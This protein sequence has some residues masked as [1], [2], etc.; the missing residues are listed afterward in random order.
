MLYLKPPYYL[1]NGVTVFRD[2]E[3]P[4]QFYF[5]PA[6][7]RLTMLTE[8]GG[9][10]IPQFQLIKFRGRAGNGGFLNFDVNLGVPGETLEEVRRELRSQEHLTEDPRLSPVLLEDGSVKMMLFGKQSPAPTPPNP[11]PGPTPNPATPTGPQF[12]LKIDHHAK[13]SLYGDNQAAFSVQLDQEGVTVLE[14][15]MKGE[16]SPIGVVYW[17]DYLAL[18]PAYNVRLSVDW[19]RTQHHFEEHFGVDALFFQADIDKVVD[20]LIDKRVIVLEADTFI[21]EGD[22]DGVS[23]RRDQAL[24][25]VRDMITD[26]FFTPSLNPYEEKRDGWDRASD[27]LDRLSQGPAGGA[28]ALFSYSRLD[29]TRIDRKSLNISISERT[30]VKRSI[31]PQGHLSGIFRTL[32]REGLDPEKFILG[33]DLDD[34]WFERR[35]VKIVGRTDFAA[36]G[37]NSVNVRLRYG[38]QLKNVLLDASKP[39]AELD[40]ASVVRRD[41]SMIR[42]VEAEYTVNFKSTDGGERPAQLT[43]K[44]FTFEGDNLEIDPRADGLYTLGSV[45]IVALNFP[46]ERY[47]VVEV[48]LRYTD[49]PNGI[50]QSDTFLLREDKTEDRWQRFIRDPERA[51]FLSQIICRAADGRDEIGEWT[52][53]TDDQIIIRDPNPRKHVLA[54]VPNFRWSEVDRAFVDLLYEDRAN[55]VQ[56]AEAFEFSESQAATRSFVV[57]LENPELREVSYTVT[58]LFKDGRTLEIPRSVTRA[59][60]VIVSSQMR[61]HR[62]IQVSPP[63]SAAFGQKRLKSVLVSLRYSDADH[64]LSYRDEFTFTPNTLEPQFF[65]FDYVDPQRQRYAFDLKY[66]FVNNLNRTVPD[67]MSGDGLLQVPVPA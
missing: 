39:T 56:Q 28:D 20:E 25:Q 55:G 7:P 12:V 67:Q 22:E 53:S 16:M 49:A 23:G 17:L 33:V 35:R 47:P 43:S 45:P 34:P 58:V 41:G 59:P 11:T 54:V 15:A 1:I 29:Y 52:S 4:R 50:R 64:R 2:H 57:D 14:Q 3:D 66:T 18:R 10:R 19:E 6:A 40:W 60:R 32:T 36:D 5:L 37:I 51:G 48:H 8:E 26:A 31:Y 13:P 30:T 63:A 24:D 9:Q 65:E 61:G 21:P 38:G 62:V 44:L 42:E 27:F 46:W